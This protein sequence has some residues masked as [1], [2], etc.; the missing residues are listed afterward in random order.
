M[1]V[2]A[3]TLLAPSVPLILTLR[4]TKEAD[5][6]ENPNIT[7]DARRASGDASRIEER[8]LDRGE[9]DPRA[10]EAAADEAFVEDQRENP[11]HPARRQREMDRQHG[12]ENPAHSE[13]I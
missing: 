5:M 8:M 12:V 2:P 10:M 6:R 11:D 3:G 1:L 4:A 9:R 13:G 7:D